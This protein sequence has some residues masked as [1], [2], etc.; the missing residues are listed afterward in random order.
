LLRDMAVMKITPGKQQL[1]NADLKEYVDRISNAMDLKGIIGLYQRFNALKRY[2]YFN[3][4]KS[5]TWNYAGSLL[6]KDIGD[7]YA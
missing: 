1:I 6:R 7:S 2:I 5:L 4:N 3:L